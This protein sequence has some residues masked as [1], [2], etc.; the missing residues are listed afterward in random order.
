MG[1]TLKNITFLLSNTTN[2]VFYNQTYEILTDSNGRYYG[3]LDVDYENGD[4]W[5]I[6][7]KIGQD[8]LTNK[9][10]VGYVPYAINSEKVGGKSLEEIMPTF[11]NK[12]TTTYKGNLTYGTYWGYVAGDYLCDSEFSGTHLCSFSEIKHTISS[13]NISGL[14][15]FT[16]EAWMA[17]GS[18]K[19]SPA[20][21]PVNDC[22]G[23]KWNKTTSYL[24]NWWKFNQDTGGEGKTGHCGN[25]LPLAC[26]K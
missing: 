21:L 2:N 10:K 12:T 9:S 24:G 7:F 22:N 20:A 13:T 14:A 6:Q 26:C 11:Y 3:Y 23:F 18:A 8:N 5:D 4:V 1:E 19:Y 16:G 15:S 25:S 17:T